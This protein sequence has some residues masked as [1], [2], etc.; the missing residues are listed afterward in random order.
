[1]TTIACWFNQEQQNHSIWV[2]GDSKISS[3]NTSLLESGAKIFSIPVICFAP[4]LSGFFDKQIYRSDIGLAYAGSSLVGLNLNAVLTTCLSRL[5]FIH[6]LPS[7]DDIVEFAG[8]LIRLYVSQLSVSSGAAALCEIAIVGFCTLEHKLKIYHLLPQS[9]DAGIVYKSEVYSDGQTLDNF[10]LLL[11]AD[12]KRI[13]SQIETERE[14][15]G[16]GIAWWRVPKRVI[17]AEISSPQHCSIG[18]H[19]QLG[20]CNQLGF[21]VYSLCRPSPNQFLSYLGFDVANDIGTIGGC[22]VGM[23]GMT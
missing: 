13:L 3:G 19:P 21:Y 7:L 12:K 23:P 1:M 15:Y 14:M 9:S 2:C 8:R 20:I 4:G 18:G 6:Q 11:G 16:S 10:V 17:E 5:N 22:I